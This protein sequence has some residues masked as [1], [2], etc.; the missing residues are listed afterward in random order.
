M[1]I[2]L[3]EPRDPL[4]VRDGRPF[5]PD[6]GAWA[7]S[8]PFPFPSTIAGG[9]RARSGLDE[10]GAF[11]YAPQDKEQLERLK[12]IS[13]RGPLL[14]QLEDESN[15]IA[16]DEWLVPLPHDVQFF[17]AGSSGLARLLRLVP[18]QSPADARTDFDREGQERHLLFVG[19]VDRTLRKPLSSKLRYLH[20]CQFQNWLIDPAR[21][22]NEHGVILSD[23]ETALGRNDL[24]RDQRLHVSMDNDRDAGKDGLLFGTSGLEFTYPGDVPRLH[25]AKR[26]ALAVDVDGET[27]APGV[28][29]FAGERRMV[30][31]RKSEAQLPECPSEIEQAIK[32]DRQCR[33][34]LLTPGCFADGYYPVTWLHT[35]AERLGIHIDVRAIVVRRPQVVSGWD[36]ELRKPKPAR[37]LVPAGTVM[38]LSLRGGDDAALSSWISEIWMHCVSDGEQDRRDGFGLAALGTW[39]GQPIAME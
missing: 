6:P 22:E 26:L 29:G 9:V 17:A 38:F 13:I 16:K 12:K 14:V 8:L 32:H 1:T 18:L 4:I 37:R 31:W 20:W 24:V 21:L 23:L 2:W 35:H 5:G 27:V 36:L 34:I 25:N 7:T 19:H 10:N 33:L 39:S 28:T 11:K 3:V 15:D 30:V